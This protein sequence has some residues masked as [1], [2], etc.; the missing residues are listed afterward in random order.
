MWE[1]ITDCSKQLNIKFRVRQALKEEE[2]IYLTEYI[3]EE[4]NID[5]YTLQLVSKQKNG[6]TI[7]L[8]PSQTMV[9]TCDK[10]LAYNFEIWKENA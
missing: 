5:E 1:K 2:E 7:P 9:L 8:D 4:I 6:H 3:I 10:I